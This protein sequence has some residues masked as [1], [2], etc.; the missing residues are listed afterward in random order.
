M[1]V[2][3]ISEISKEGE[4]SKQQIVYGFRRNEQGNYKQ[5]HTQ[6]SEGKLVT[7]FEKGSAIN[8]IF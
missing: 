4:C 8:S 7:E 5:L 6:Q 1:S 2:G 3:K